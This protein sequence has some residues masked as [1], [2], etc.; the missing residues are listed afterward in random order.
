MRTVVGAGCWPGKG[1]GPI[2]WLEG[3]QTWSRDPVADRAAEVLR[4]R[5]ELDR[6]IMDVDTWSEQQETVAAR[7]TLQGY[8]DALLEDAWGRRVCALIDTE[9]LP[10]AAACVDGAERVAQLLARSEALHER[11]AHLVEAAGWLAGRLGSVAHPPQAILAAHRLGVLQLLDRRQ[12]LLLADGAE[13]SILGRVPL[14]WG[15]PGLGPE[16]HGRRIAFAGTVVRLD[17]PD[18]RWWQLNG[19]LLQGHPICHLNGDVEAVARTARRL[20]C[21]PVA[22]IQRL[23]DL[24]AVPLFVAEAAAI[25]VDL[26]RLGPAPRLKHPGFELLLKASAAVAAS[27]GVPMLAGG[28]PVA[29]TPDRWLALGFTGFYGARLPQGGPQTHALRRG[30]ESSL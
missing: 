3:G 12:P 17:L 23:D 22:M 5:S 27:A 19:E 14:V 1:E 7:L 18:E 6:A 24:A 15:V 10:A 30:K 2:V 29:K 26:D 8:R 25:A 9:G 11:A 21:K 4:F 16:W 28:E 13:P 20:G